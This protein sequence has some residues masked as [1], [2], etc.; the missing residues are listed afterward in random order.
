MEEV[1]CRWIMVDSPQPGQEYMPIYSSSMV[2]F[3]VE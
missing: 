3:N 1:L 2:V